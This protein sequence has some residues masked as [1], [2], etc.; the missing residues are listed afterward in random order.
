MQSM[1]GCFHNHVQS[2]CGNAITRESFMGLFNAAASVCSSVEP[3][4]IE[5][6]ANEIDNNDLHNVELL[7]R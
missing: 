7:S 3:T 5:V 6:D 4:S 1:K 2:S